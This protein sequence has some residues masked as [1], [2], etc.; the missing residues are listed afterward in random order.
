[1]RYGDVF[2]ELKNRFNVL[3]IGVSRGEGQEYGLSKLP[4]PSFEVRAGDYLIVLTSGR[5]VGELNGVFGCS[6]GI[7]Y[8]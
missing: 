3:V 6:E 7:Y 8:A 5:S 1:M 2:D 4:E